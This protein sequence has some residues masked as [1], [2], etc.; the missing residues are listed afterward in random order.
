MRRFIS[1]L[2]Y[3]LLFFVSWT[4]AVADVSV[5]KNP[6]GPLKVALDIGL[7][8]TELGNPAE[9]LPPRK[10]NTLLSTHLTFSRPVT[11]LYSD[12]QLWK[13]ARDAH[14]EMPAELQQYGLKNI[15]RPAAMTILVWDNHMLL[16]SSQ[17]GQQFIYDSPIVTQVLR[18]LQ[19]CQATAG[20]SERHKNKG[21]CGEEMSAHIYYIYH[22]TG[23]HLRDRNPQATVGTWV[24]SPTN[25]QQTDPCGEPG[26]WG[27]DY[28]VSDKEG[29]Q[30]LRVLDKDIAPADS[31]AIPPDTIIDQW[32][33][34]G[35]VR[36][37]P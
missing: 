8:R 34:C 26:A 31:Y 33:I 15:N 37:H 2:G 29:G 30:N 6:Q 22:P 19:I 13:I 14:A 16:V 35:T 10:A 32:Q 7:A 12:A 17:K 4:W 23:P 36:T 3:I 25:A 11:E 5:A 18:D 20:S 28:F 27:C 21:T 9:P 1:T 24:G